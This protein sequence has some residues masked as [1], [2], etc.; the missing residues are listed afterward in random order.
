MKVRL[1]NDFY[2]I[3][4]KNSLKKWFLTKLNSTAKNSRTAVFQERLA[5]NYKWD[6][7]TAR[8]SWQ[9]THSYLVDIFFTIFTVAP[10]LCIP[11]VILGFCF[12]LVTSNTVIWE[13]L[14]GAHRFKLEVEDFIFHVVV[15]SRETFQTLAWKFLLYI[16]QKVF[17]VY[18][19]PDFVLV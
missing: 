13:S 10:F 3:S 9:H 8:I 18:I 2:E 11:S 7:L 17:R 15:Y 14:F 6:A 12:I 19:F 1:R 4:E 16:L 5:L